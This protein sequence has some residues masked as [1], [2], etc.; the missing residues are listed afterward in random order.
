MNSSLPGSPAHG[1]FQARILEWAA[2]SSFM[3]S[4]LPRDQT[5]ISCVSCF[6][7]RILYDYNRALRHM[8]S[9]ISFTRYPQGRRL[10]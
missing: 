8:T 5:D 6:G 2:I 9:Y 3:R 7:R 1:V 10:H 4:S